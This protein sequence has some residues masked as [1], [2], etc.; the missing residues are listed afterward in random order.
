MSTKKKI[1]DGYWEAADGSLHHIDSIKPID[2]QRDAVVRGIVARAAVLSEQLSGLKAELMGDVDSFVDESAK[3]Y[4]AK[5]GGNKGNVTLL[6]FDG[7]YKVIRAKQDNLTFD[8]RLQAAKHLIDECLRD[9]TSVKGVPSELKAIV[10]RAF[11]TDAAGNISVGRVLDLRRVDIKDPRWMNAMQAISDAIQVTGSK[12]YLRVYVRDD[13][14]G[15]YKQ[16]PLD[17]AGA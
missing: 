8:E 1:P 14:T 13:K 10:S 6:T 3:K 16:M 17:M 4:K 7:K 11:R 5:L 2:A 15:K 9:W 12:P